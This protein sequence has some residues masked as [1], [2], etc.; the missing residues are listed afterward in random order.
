MTSS[1]ARNFSTMSPELG[2]F[3]AN[4]YETIKNNYLKF[5]LL[6]LY[7]A[8][9]ITG[10]YNVITHTNTSKITWDIPC[11]EIFDYIAD[12]D[13]SKEALIVTDTEVIHYYTKQEYR[14]DLYINQHSSY[15]EDWAKKIASWKGSVIILKTH[16][17]HIMDDNFK[18][19]LAFLEQLDSDT[20]VKKYEFGVDKFAWFKRKFDKEITDYLVKLYFIE[21]SK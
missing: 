9:T 15:S 11:R 1:G 21:R 3:L 13:P 5:V 6:F 2:I 14:N 19:Y 10:L 18:K 7:S 20:N 4:I 16:S 12:I 17:F 8:G